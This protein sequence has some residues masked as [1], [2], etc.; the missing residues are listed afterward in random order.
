M[1]L[2]STEGSLKERGVR[3]TRQRQILLELIDKTGEHL[4]AERLYQMAKEKDPKL[5]RV[6]VYRTLNTFT[7]KKLVHRVRGEDRGWRYALGNSGPAA[8]HRHPHFVCEDCG[9]VECLGD[10][11]IPASFVRSLGVAPKYQVQYP[12]VVLHGLCPRCAG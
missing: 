7:R 8:E 5:N 2:D 1:A 4:D 11:D 9:K 6:T 3:L 12:E 10:A